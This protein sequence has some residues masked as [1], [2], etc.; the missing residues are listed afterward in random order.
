MNV[1]VFKNI[2]AD[3]NFDPQNDTVTF[4]DD[5][6]KNVCFHLTNDINFMNFV[7]R[8]RFSDISNEDIALCKKNNIKLSFI[9]LQVNSLKPTKDSF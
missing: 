4:Y 7:I 1:N 9:N 6:I 2:F 8:G 3:I 5:S